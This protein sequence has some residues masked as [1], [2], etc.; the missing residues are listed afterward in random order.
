LLLHA[1]A[2]ATAPAAAWGQPGPEVPQ[3]D[4]QYQAGPKDG[5]SCAMCQLFRPPD[6]C[7]VVAGNISP[8]GWCKFFAM[9]D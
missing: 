3:A 9:P 5:M 7:A 4:A 8:R 2:V 6:R 1:L